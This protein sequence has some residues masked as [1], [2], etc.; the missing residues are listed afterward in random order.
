MTAAIPATIFH[1]EVHAVRLAAAACASSSAS[2]GLAGGMVF[3]ISWNIPSCWA[4]SKKAL[5]LTENLAS[6]TA[7][8]W[9]VV[10]RTVYGP[11][12]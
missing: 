11:T 6:V 2:V 7:P 8:V 5:V 10:S 3:T 12:D 4:G 1:H 9:S